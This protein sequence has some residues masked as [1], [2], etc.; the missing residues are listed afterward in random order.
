VTRPWHALCCFATHVETSAVLLCELCADTGPV[1][2]IA[3]ADAHGVTQA[4]LGWYRR[5]IEFGAGD[6]VKR[7]TDRR[8]RI[9]STLPEF[10][11]VLDSVAAATG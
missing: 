2:A 9:R 7:A 6:S 4:A 8:D 10:A 3:D 11:A 5:W 1:S